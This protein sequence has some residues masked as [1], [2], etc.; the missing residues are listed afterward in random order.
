[1]LAQQTQTQSTEPGNPIG[2]PVFTTGGEQ[3]GEVIQVATYGGQ[4]A[5]RAEIGK[6]LGMGATTVIIPDSMIQRK[7]D[8]LEVNM[9]ASEVRETIAKQR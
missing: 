1:V 7:T 9:T 8:R 6:F 4:P 3:L 2:L 5:V